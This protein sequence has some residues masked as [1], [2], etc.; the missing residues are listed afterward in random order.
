MHFFPDWQP[1]SALS[2]SCVTVVQVNNVWMYLKDESR[3]P[4]A[5]VGDE[6]NKK[7]KRSKKKKNK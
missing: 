4:I 5:V 2:L 6:N 1:L 3:V 7:N